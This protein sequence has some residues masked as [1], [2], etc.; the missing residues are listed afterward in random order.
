MS[1]DSDATDQPARI[2]SYEVILRDFS[3]EELL[4]ELQR[5][6][7]EDP[8]EAAGDRLLA[9]CIQLAQGDE[10]IK[11]IKKW[12]EETKKVGFRNI[13]SDYWATEVIPKIANVNHR[14]RVAQLAADLQAEINEK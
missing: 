12:A 6:E 9:F 14:R 7:I 4:D 11:Q 13:P 5:R 8:I 3:T 2:R 1:T 10:Q